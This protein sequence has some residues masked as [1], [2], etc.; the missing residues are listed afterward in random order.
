MEAGSSYNIDAFVSIGGRY[1][2][3]DQTNYVKIYGDGAGGAIKKHWS[4]AEN[5]DKLRGFL[6]FLVR[7]GLCLL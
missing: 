4:K 1:G 2:S 7:R 6:Q 5:K 3:G